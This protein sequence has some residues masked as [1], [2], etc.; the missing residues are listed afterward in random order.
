M[1][2][3]VNCGELRKQTRAAFASVGSKPVA[4]HTDISRIGVPEGATSKDAIKTIY[5]EIL[6][7]IA[8]ERTVLVPTFN[9]DFCKTGVFSVEGDPSQLGQFTEYMRQRTTLRTQTPVFNFAVFNN[10][11]CPLEPSDNPFGTS[12]TFQW[13]MD[14]D[15]WVAFYGAKFM[16]N[17]FVHYIEESIPITYRYHKRF[18]GVVTIGEVSQKIEL[19][20]RV[21][22]MIPGA[23]DYDWTRLQNETVEAG[24]V[25]SHGVGR[26][27]VLVFRCR[28]LYDFWRNK[29][30]RDDRYLLTAESR[31]KTDDLF[32][33]YGCPLTVLAVEG[34]GASS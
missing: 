31:M 30:L 23:V 13:L 24:I 6:D 15:G 19:I 14:N 1:G 34:A 22:P 25:E 9:Y 16:Y 29:M 27:E 18:P 17:T 5:G 11:G 21:K 8:S 2:F 20:Y 3:L 4:I 12:S 10:S 28:A 26:G 33:R 7:A 32:S